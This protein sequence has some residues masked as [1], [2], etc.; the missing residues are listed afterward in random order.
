M[1]KGFSEETLNFM[2]NIR[3]NNER[4]WFEAH[5]DE[6]KNFLLG[7]MNLLASEVYAAFAEKHPELKLNLHVSR[8]YRDA[9]RLHG[10][11]PYKD[12]L[13]FSIRSD[14]D[15]WIHLP[16]FWFELEPE[17]WSYGMGYYS[18]KAETMAKHRAR[19]DKQSKRM[20][21]LALSL[22][23]QS[24]FILGGEEYAR[25]K[26]NPG[27]LLNEWYNKKNFFLIHEENT[28]AALFSPELSKR[29]ADG[30][31]YLSVFY[32]YFSSLATDA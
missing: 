18:A 25:P 26:G 29:I 17:K 9:R 31:D 24:E 32:K 6:Y 23:G 30:F 28:G 1:F 5:K 4:S 8:I 20:E 16:T 12:H 14:S 2:W 10:K 13:W 3:F 19:I 22:K 15:E 7:P 27:E 11:G 21:E